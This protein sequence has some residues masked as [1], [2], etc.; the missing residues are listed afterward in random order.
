MVRYG[1]RVAPN[2]LD[3]ASANQRYESVFD[4]LLTVERVK[5]VV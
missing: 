2:V 3:R 5:G 4:L 1:D